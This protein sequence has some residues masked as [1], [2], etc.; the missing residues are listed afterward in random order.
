[1]ATIPPFIPPAFPPPLSAREKE[2]R[3]LYDALQDVQKCL[4]GVD[5]EEESQHLSMARNI[6]RARPLH[7][8]LDFPPPELPYD[9]YALLPTGRAAILAL[10][11]L[12]HLYYIALIG[13][14]DTHG[15]LW[16]FDGSI[17]AYII[18]W[19][20]YL[21]PIHAG[22]IPPEILVFEDKR[23]PQLLVMVAVGLFECIAC[24]PAP[25]ARKF[26][27]DSDNGT[28][29][30]LVSLWMLWPKLSKA[31]Y[32]Q[33]LHSLR[34]QTVFLDLWQLFDRDVA[35]RV[36]GV[37][38]RHLISGPKEAFRVCAEHLRAQA[39]TGDLA[40]CGDEL[41]RQAA[42]VLAILHE[43][44]LG[45]QSIPCSFVSAVTTILA[46]ELADA[47][48]CHDV[49][50][51]ILATLFVLC[52]RSDHAL[53]LAIKYGIFPMTVR[54]RQLCTH[55]SSGA[56]VLC[57]GLSIT[58]GTCG[59][60]VAF[61]GTILCFPRAVQYFH[62]AQG[63]FAGRM[64]T[65][66]LRED[67]QELVAFAE[68][69]YKLL[70]IAEREWPLVAVCCNPTCIA[71]DASLRSCPC[72]EA[73]YCSK[74]CQRVHLAH[75]S[76]H[77]RECTMNVAAHFGSPRTM[78]SLCSKDVHFLAVIARAYVEENYST[79]MAAT[80]GQPS[81]SDCVV[82]G[83]HLIR[84]T[85]ERTFVKLCRNV[86][87]RDACLHPNLAVKM[88]YEQTDGPHNRLVILAP[89]CAPWQYSQDFRM[90]K[91]MFYGLRACHFLGLALMHA[92]QTPKRSGMTPTED[93]TGV[94]SRQ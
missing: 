37:Q 11:T 17:W 62:D 25:E 45:P 86:L 77:R 42:L 74:N 20:E 73:L 90:I 28:A 15:S 29:Q 8:V 49:W 21:L 31:V 41:G 23:V 7:V 5:V 78:R 39:A 18:R 57:D 27:L 51:Q 33:A 66:P 68:R 12:Q 80:G 83:L 94:A 76:T 72:G 30:S 75:D 60:F 22:Q 52:S 71:Q 1:M 14:K 50:A 47:P 91:S 79:I 10:I 36:F 16:P 35:G 69:R 43:Y 54:V 84:A 55:C 24:C 81:G 88:Q 56:P 67:E 63:M 53:M 65:I 44:D 9:I 82:I 40:R 26:F 48:D 38:I 6:L 70:R 87:E 46:N 61:I 89:R 32:V 93:G 59:G 3:K 92:L 64:P 85:E 19:T 34:F 2:I 13:P 4:N 58:N